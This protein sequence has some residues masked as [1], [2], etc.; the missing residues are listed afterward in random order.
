MKNIFGC[1]IILI[2]SV[3]GAFAY[4]VIDEGLNGVTSENG[5][6]LHATLALN[7]G[8]EVIWHYNVTS[9][10]GGSTVFSILCKV[11]SQNNF[12]VK[13]TYYGQYD[14]YFVDTIADAGGSTSFWIYYIN[15]DMG[16]VGADK[17]LVNEGDHIEWRLEE[18]S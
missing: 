10:N 16:N 3:S 8:D 7:F 4:Y 9:Q 5:S 12:S 11:A 6:M 1:A 17:K 13:S 2:I 18:F 14:S 15:G